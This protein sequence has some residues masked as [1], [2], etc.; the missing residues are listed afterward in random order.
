MFECVRRGKQREIV[1]FGG[2]YDSLLEH[3]KEPA[4]QMPSRK[5]FGVGM[6]IAVE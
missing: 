2:R 3:F 4:L 6:S 1:A 5:V